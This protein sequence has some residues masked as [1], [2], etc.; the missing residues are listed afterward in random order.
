MVRRRMRKPRRRR[1]VLARATIC[2]TAASPPRPSS[3]RPRPPSRWPKRRSGRRRPIWPW[4]SLPA[5][6]E[7]IKAARDAGQAGMGSARTGEMA[8]GQAL[9]RSALARP[10]RRR[11]PQPR[12]CR[13]AVRTG[14]LDAARRR[15]EADAVRARNVR[16]RRS[17]SASILEVRCDGCP[18]GLK[19]RV[20]Y[21][22]PDPEFTPPVIYSLET[23][24][25]LVY[26]VEARPDGDATRC[27]P[28]RSSMWMLRGMRRE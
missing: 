1:R 24:Q 20:S 13:R 6:P 4:P 25:K 27:S 14:H 15:G 26:L 11:H 23:R 10:H 19:A 12:R 28:G 22:S 9:D 18:A 21:V 16:S 8:A 5:R 17:R 7:T 3:T 2:S